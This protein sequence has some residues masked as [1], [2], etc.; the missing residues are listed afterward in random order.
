M[1]CVCVCVVVDETERNRGLHKRITTHPKAPLWL[2]GEKSNKKTPPPSTAISLQVQEVHAGLHA[3]LQ[4]VRLPL[5][6]GRPADLSLGR[7]RDAR[8]PGL[9]CCRVQAPHPNHVLA[10]HDVQAER[11]VRE[12]GPGDEALDS[13][14]EDEVGELWE[15]R[16]TAV[17]VVSEMEVGRAC[18]FFRSRWVSPPFTWSNDLSTP[19]ILRP[20]RSWTISFSSSS[21]YA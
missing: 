4:L 1:L 9:I 18:F 2:P 13:V 21:S 3:P 16:D 6:L 5:R 19:M 10:A 15:K 12:D 7:A 14:L 20:S 11:D 17:G 8:R